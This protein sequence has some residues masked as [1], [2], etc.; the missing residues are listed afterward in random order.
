MVFQRIEGVS[1]ITGAV[2]PQWEKNERSDDCSHLKL[3]NQAHL[4]ATI[5]RAIT[6]KT[7]MFV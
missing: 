1:V 6:L 3:I 4:C 7:L 2:F 5:K